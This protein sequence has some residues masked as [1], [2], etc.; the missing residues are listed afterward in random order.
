MDFKSLRYVL[1]VAEKGGI[2]A[3]ARELGISQPSLSKY[4]QHLA[5]SLKVQLF[6]RGEGGL[7]PTYAGTRYI[8]AA[9]KMLAVA[10][11]LTNIAP[12]PEEKPLRITC[13]PYEGSYIHPF[14]I[15]RFCELFPDANL[16]TIESSDSAGLLRSGE[17]DVAITTSVLP[18]KEFVHSTLT[19]D[20]ILLATSRKHPVGKR[21]VWK[22]KCLRPWVDVKEL[23]GEALIRLF[24]DQRTRILSDELLARERVNLR[25]L[26]Q[27]RSV[28]N[29]I[30]V[31]STGAGICFAPA[32][33]MRHYQFN[34]PP[35][36]FSVGDPILMD[37][38]CVRLR[39]AH[40]GERVTKFVKL[41]SDFI[42]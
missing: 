16:M 5:D 1:A 13:T 38:Y 25:A 36:F 9:R 31:A 10:E 19:R 6:E 17:A 14:A 39:D 26:M 3:A 7:T 21:A 22:E 4:L 29:A 35:A 2:S 41:I 42:S 8:A 12:R 11:K 24:P 28:L 18:G 34:E 30:R 23:W 32:L 37:V 20:E 40:P 15:K 33:G 27:T